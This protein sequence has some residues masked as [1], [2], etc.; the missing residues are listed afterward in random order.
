MALADNFTALDRARLTGRIVAELARRWRAVTIDELQLAMGLRPGLMDA[1]AHTPC[2]NRPG[3]WASAD[4]NPS[5]PLFGATIVFTGTTAIP[6]AE[7]WEWANQYGASIGER[8]TRGTTCLVIGD[9]FSGTKLPEQGTLAV[10]RAAAYIAD[11]QA[12]SVMDE[13]TFTGLLARDI[14]DR[15]TFLGPTWSELPDWVKRLRSEWIVDQDGDVISRW[16]RR[17][18]CS[19]CSRGHAIPSGDVIGRVH[20]SSCEASWEVTVLCSPWGPTTPRGQRGD[21]IDGSCPVCATPKRLLAPTSDLDF[22]CRASELPR[23]LTSIGSPVTQT[24]ANVIVIAHSPMQEGHAEPSTRTCFDEYSEASRDGWYRSAPVWF[25]HCRG[26][27]K[28]FAART[29]GQEFCSITCG[30]MKP[31]HARELRRLAVAAGPA[32]D[33]LKVFER[34][35]W[36]CYLC[37]KL[38]SLDAKDPLARASID[39]V[40]P[41]VLGGHHSWENVMT[42][43]LR[44]NLEKSDNLPTLEQFSG[45]AAVSQQEQ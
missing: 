33:R 2:W 43:H 5:N 8:V 10:R 39:H 16:F 6:R 22:T 23:E 37:G 14:V 4:A 17:F 30:P 18:G 26:C 3:N 45:R 1:Q 11:G 31:D 7:N 20:C 19:N 32:I 24:Q 15:S 38:T 28:L 12:L 9:G 27:G 42:T 36:V 21:W 34:D 41:I 25:T 44:C 40:T 29:S 35:N 13:K